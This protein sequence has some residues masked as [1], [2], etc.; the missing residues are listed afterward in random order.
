MKK[1]LVLAVFVLFSNLSFSQLGGEDEVYLGGEFIEAK[2]QNGGIDK[3]YDYIIA[4]FDT[5][6]VEKKGQIV[7]EFTVNENGEVKNIKVVRDLGSNSAIEL[8]RV[9]RK[10]PKWQPASR[11]GKPVSINLKMPLTF[12]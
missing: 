5:Q 9:L 11:G 1:F 2:F 7:F 6:T 10:A 8:I 4:N 12:K 3:F